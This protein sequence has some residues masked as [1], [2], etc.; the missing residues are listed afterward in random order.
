MAEQSAEESLPL[1]VVRVD[2]TRFPQ[3]ATEFSIKGFPTI[4]F[5]QPN[6]IV[7]YYGDRTA[8][9]ILDFARRLS[10][11][12][13]RSLASCNDLAALARKRRVFFVHFTDKSIW[14]NYSDSA[15]VF[16]SSDWFYLVK[17]TCAGYEPNSVYVVKNS[18]NHFKTYRYPIEYFINKE[19]GAVSLVE[20][21]KRE[22]YPKFIRITAANLDHFLNT[23]KTLVLLA[24]E[25][26]PYSKRI[27][28]STAEQAHF[29]K[30][31][32]LANENDQESELMFAWTDQLDMLNSLLLRTVSPLP[33][34]ILI[35]STDSTHHQV[36]HSDAANQIALIVKTLT[37]GD[38]LKKPQFVG[39][40]W[41][42]TPMH[43]MA[44]DTYA[45]MRQ[46]YTANPV[47]TVILF[48][49]PACLVTLLVYCACFTNFLEGSDEEFAEDEEDEDEDDEVM[50]RSIQ[51]DAHNLQPSYL[52]DHLKSD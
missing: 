10:G 3:V 50:D 9:E 38:S 18:G 27:T 25:H 7:E 17:Q 33:A 31:E 46:M 44:F 42:L 49:L 16:H 20:W 2:C 34:Y 19:N 41:F 21:I 40:K 36:H 1:Y 43:R 37:L 26:N 48:G 51:Y 30:L 45:G 35:N 22:R 52:N 39:G 29:D 5:V 32:Q 14:T 12:P 13:M 28:L 15:K 4:M 24:I 6:R 11:P 23:H 47:L 8:E